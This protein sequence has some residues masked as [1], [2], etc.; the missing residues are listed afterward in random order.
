MSST[1]SG[2]LSPEKRRQRA[3]L[4]K[5]TAFLSLAAVFTVWV[6]AVTGE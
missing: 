5:F 2:R 1:S 4:V 3:D 6:A